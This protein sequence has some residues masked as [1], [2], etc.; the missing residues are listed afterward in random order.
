MRGRVCVV[1]GATSGIG[2]ATATALARLGA[3]VLMVARAPARA[4]SAVRHVI[5]ETGNSDVSFVTCDLSSL[6]AIEAATREI[7][8]RFPAV[9]V[10][11]NNAGV[12]IARRRLSV[13]GIETTW[14]VN[15]LAP[16]L[17]TKRLLPLLQRGSPSLV[18]NVSSEFARWGRLRLGDPEH[19]RGFYNGTLA[20]VESKLAN[21][22]FTLSLAERA[23]NTGVSSVC[24]YP[25]LSV[26]RLLS[27]RW[28]W[29][30]RLLKPLWRILFRTP[31]QGAEPVVRAIT[32][33]NVA[34]MNGRCFDS[35]GRE[36]RP[37]RSVRDPDVRRRLW[38][39]SDRAVERTRR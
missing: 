12:S 10:L 24:V 26:T 20:Y 14:A 13:D 36:V 16:F 33:S 25:G 35:S 21:V 17:L 8:A 38:A 39:E 3:S 27:D 23:K 29:R 22:A 18:V 7:A 5:D 30:S 6:A 37:P 1:T 4:E 2:K 34:E 19:A 28:W 11:V 15:H 32:A 31:T 9:H